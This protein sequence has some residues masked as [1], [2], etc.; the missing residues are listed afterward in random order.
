[1]NLLSKTRKINALLQNPSGKSVNYK[2]MS[3]T[4]SD[5]MEANVFI[6]GSRGNLLGFAVHDQIE[7]EQMNELFEILQFSEKYFKA[8]RRETSIL[9]A[10]SEHTVSTGDNKGI[11][12]RGLSTIVPIIGGGERLGTLVIERVKKPFYDDDL[13]LAEYSS[14]V[15]GMEILRGKA[16]KIEE[17]ARNKAIGQVAIKT[18]SYSELEAVE[19]IFEE[20]NGRKEGLLVTSKVAD[21]FEIA[22][23]SIVNALRK[24]GGAGIIE[25][26]SLG[27][28]GTHIKVLND[29]FFLK[30]EKLKSVRS[31]L[32]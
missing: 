2:K 17:E 25:S 13:F 4:F 5:A 20:L 23:S 32:A 6:I 11:Y 24:L 30:L 21:R 18:L 1:M 10:H 22:R 27:V 14:V 28:K 15:V 19:H 8:N 9:E 26:H 7:D 12:Q 29:K 31:H 16:E 3:E